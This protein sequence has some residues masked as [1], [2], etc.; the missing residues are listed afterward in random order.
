MIITAPD[1]IPT[2]KPMEPLTDV[3]F[4]WYKTML[5]SYICNRA[6]YI[7]IAMSVHA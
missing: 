6:S 2:K 3:C 4:T 5:D 1:A 7:F